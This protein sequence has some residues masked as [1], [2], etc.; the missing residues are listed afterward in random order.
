MSRAHWMFL[1]KK[2]GQV[3]GGVPSSS[4]FSHSVATTFKS[5]QSGSRQH[6]SNVSHWYICGDW[7]LNHHTRTQRKKNVFFNSFIYS[8]WSLLRCTIIFCCLS[9]AVGVIIFL[10]LMWYPCLCSNAFTL[11]WAYIN[12]PI[13]IPSVHESLL[14]HNTRNITNRFSIVSSVVQFFVPSQVLLCRK[15]LV[16]Q[17]ARVI[18]GTSIWNFALLT[19][20]VQIKFPVSSVVTRT[21]H[22]FRRV[23]EGFLMHSFLVGPQVT[24]RC[25]IINATS[26][27]N[28]D[29]TI[30]AVLFLMCCPCVV[31]QFRFA[32]EYLV[33]VVA[34]DLHL[35]VDTPHV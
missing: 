28:F 30:K 13:Q 19:V 14:A 6:E 7:I 22:Q 15:R 35:S 27:T 21:T 9:A 5:P 17:V 20:C 4:N 10:S 2:N 18:D 23:W 16:A 8:K 33:T 1:A 32:L 29:I 25:R 26:I 34:R 31:F 12:V 11:K 24:F 3:G